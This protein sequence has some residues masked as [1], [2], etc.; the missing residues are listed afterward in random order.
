[1]KNAKTHCFDWPQDINNVS[2]FSHSNDVDNVGYEVI[3]VDLV[4]FEQE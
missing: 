3:K 1:M 4:I 2:Y